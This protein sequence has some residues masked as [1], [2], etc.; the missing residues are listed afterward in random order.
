M[1]GNIR[2]NAR[3][4]V[5]VGSE[6][7]CSEHR[8]MEATWVH[9]KSSI[10]RWRW[11]ERQRSQRCWLWLLWLLL[12]WSGM[13]ASWHH[14]YTRKPGVQCQQPM[15]A[16]SC[17]P[18]TASMSGSTVIQV[19]CCGTSVRRCFLLI[20][21]PDQLDLRQWRI[22]LSSVTTTPELETALTI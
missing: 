11:R 3:G 22:F 19:C 1:E 15:R 21:V 9:S 2:S 20:S 4:K 18:E 8:D 16:K 12:L 13:I 17:R 14:G 5:G 10:G 6:Q 7:C